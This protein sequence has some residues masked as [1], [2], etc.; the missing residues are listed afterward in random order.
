[1]I[2]AA[3]LLAQIVPAPDAPE[4]CSPVPTALPAELRSWRRPGIDLS[5][6]RAVTIASA[7]PAT[8][9]LSYVPAPSRPGRMILRTIRIARAGT[10]G[11]ALDQAGWIDLYHAGDRAPLSSV[12]HGHGPD[13]SGIRKI[14]RFAL[15]P[16]EYRVLVTGLQKPRATL[17]LVG[18]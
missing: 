18:G 1:M 4:T 16:G 2:L 6:G 11:I 17:L 10:Y 13:C 8:V 7:D 5:S 15:Q 3:L 9:L 12:R 14:V